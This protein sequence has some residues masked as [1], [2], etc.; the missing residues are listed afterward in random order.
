MLFTLDEAKKKHRQQ[1][2]QYNTTVKT[3]L[4]LNKSTLLISN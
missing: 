3:G 4:Y 2:F 1:Q